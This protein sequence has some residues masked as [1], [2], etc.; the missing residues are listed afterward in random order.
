MKILSPE[1]F[2]KKIQRAAS[3]DVLSKPTMEVRPN[4]QLLLSIVEDGTFSRFLGPIP[5][6]MTDD[7]YIVF[8]SGVDIL[9]GSEFAKNFTLDRMPS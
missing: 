7:E 5:G 4:W 3:N 9:V 6:E 8:L 1:A 2:V